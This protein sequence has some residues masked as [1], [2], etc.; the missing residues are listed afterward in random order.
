M[1]GG[2]QRLSRSEHQKRIAT[3]T[4]QRETLEIEVTRR[5]AGYYEPAHVVTLDA[6]KAAIPPE[7][8]VVEFV[9]SRP[10]SPKRLWRA[11]PGTE[12]PR[13]VAYVISGRH[14]VRWKD[15]GPARDIDAA[16]EA[17]RETLRAPDRTNVKQ[18]ARAL[19]EKIVQPIRA[20]AGDAT[21]LL[22]SPDGPVALVPFEALV[23]E[24]GHYLLERYSISYL[25]AGR[26]LLRMQTVR[27]SNT[28]PLIVADPLFG[29]PAATGAS[30]SLRRER[31]STAQ[32]RRS[33][34][35]GADLTSMYFAPIASCRPRRPAASSRSFRTCRSSPRSEP[36]SK[37]S[38][39]RRRHE[40]FI[41]RRTG[42]SCRTRRR[43]QRRAHGST[44]HCCGQ[45]WP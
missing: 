10:Y 3:L 29:E 8:V 43:Q 35:A 26:D 15:L 28:P 1:L 33:V 9:V 11:Q 31:V 30:T 2:P 13:Y 39:A 4:E 27:A 17:M 38:R 19:D 45:D 34:T 37:P 40:S 23:D 44:I 42:S 24:A 22:V 32:A 41:S 7:A 5:S 16:V 36:L 6:I 12:S 18:A 20:L 25:S 21:R 14:E